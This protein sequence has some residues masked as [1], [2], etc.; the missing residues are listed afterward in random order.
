MGALSL[1]SSINTLVTSGMYRQQWE[2]LLVSSPVTANDMCIFL[3]TESQLLESRAPALFLFSGP[4]AP[5][6]KQV[7]NKSLL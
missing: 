6:T 4:R 1:T 2:R 5:G 3:L 7:F